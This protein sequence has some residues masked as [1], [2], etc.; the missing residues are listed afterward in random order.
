MKAIDHSLFIFIYLG[1]QVKVKLEGCFSRTVTLNQC[2]GEC[3]S[4]MMPFMHALRHGISR[5]FTTRASCCSIETTSDVSYPATATRYLEHSA[6]LLP[7]NHHC[8][9]Y[10]SNCDML[11]HIP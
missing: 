7:Y 5:Q 9:V 3:Q 8:C 2:L 6:M 10:K 1:V 11:P 4:V